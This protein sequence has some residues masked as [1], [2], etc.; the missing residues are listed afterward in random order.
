M[1]IDI[2]ELTT[3]VD[4]S[5]DR[6]YGKYRGQVADTNDPLQSGRVKVSV[7]EVLGDVQT[8][9]ALPCTPYA[10]KGHGLYTIPPVGA[11][12]W[13]E[14]EAGDVSRPIWTGGWWGP[15]EAP[16]APSS[17]LPSPNRRELVSETGLTVAL[18]DDSGE[19][20]IS[21]ANGT[22]LMRIKAQAG[23]IELTALTQVTIE[24]TRILHGQGATEPAVLGNQ[25]LTYLT[26]L[27]TMF[28]THLHPGELAAGVIPVTPAPPVAPFPP[29]PPT[30]L[31]LKNSVE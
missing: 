11:S 20:L 8:G 19:L 26:Q 22:N 6:F 21:D 18:D 28:N 1:P 24:A 2:A 5:T 4:A 17:P 31:S 3:S 9:W 15:S 13:V 27:V 25:L 23:Q 7:P 16:G 10:S 12:V 14:F 29:A 30:L